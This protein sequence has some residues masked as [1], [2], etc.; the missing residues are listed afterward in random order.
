MTTGIRHQTY[1]DMNGANF[2]NFLSARNAEGWATVS[3][4]FA[5]GHWWAVMKLVVVS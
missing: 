1:R 4:G 3:C 5:D 2:A